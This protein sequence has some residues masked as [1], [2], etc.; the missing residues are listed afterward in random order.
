M[1]AKFS[2]CCPYKRKE[3]GIWDPEIHRE[4]KHVKTGAGW[5]YAAVNQWVLRSHRKLAVRGSSVLPT[6]W[7]LTSGHWNWENECL[8]FWAT[9]FLVSVGSENF[10]K[11][12]HPMLFSLF[13]LTL[14]TKYS[15]RNQKFY[16]H[17]TKLTC[18]QKFLIATH[19]K[20]KS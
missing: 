20:K 16:L 13:L 18:L 12:I 17:F 15:L 11:W 7:L 19:S 5:S 14:C 1:G 10:R 6:T 9:Q 4:K 2:D 8:L 3:T